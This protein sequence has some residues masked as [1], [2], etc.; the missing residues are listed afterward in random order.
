MGLIL[1]VF[2]PICIEKNHKRQ[3]NMNNPN[4]RITI[5]F[6]IL[7]LLVTLLPVEASALSKHEMFEIGQ[8]IKMLNEMIVLA[9]KEIDMLQSENTPESLQ[10][11]QQLRRR[12]EDMRMEIRSLQ[13]KLASGKG[14]DESHYSSRN[15]DSYEP[16]NWDSRIRNS[17]RR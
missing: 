11:V 9:E 16:G 7:A 17:Q 2:V 1:A 10:Q 4:Y 15:D 13:D 14:G 3:A 5:V 8:R 6:A 12:I